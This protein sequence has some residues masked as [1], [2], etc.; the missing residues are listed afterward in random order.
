MQDVSQQKQE[1]F[2]HRL[3]ESGIKNSTNSI[4][5][6]EVNPQDL[7]A[8]KI[9]FVNQAFARMTG[10]L[11]DEI[12]AKKQIPFQGNDSDENELAKLHMAFTKLCPSSWKPF[13]II[14]VETHFGCFYPPFLC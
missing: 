10:F 11:E 9:V 12:L 13:P 7:L 4:V 6:A 1:E 3:L 14:K 2:R 5:L 8:P